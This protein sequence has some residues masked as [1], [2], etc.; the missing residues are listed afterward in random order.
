[1]ARGRAFERLLR[2]ALERHPGEYGPSRFEA[3]WLWDE[4]PDR[5]ASGYGH[6]L[7][8]DLVA[9]QSEAY[10]GGLCAIQAKFYDTGRIDKGDVDSFISAS[11]A[12]LFTSRLLMVTGSLT[13]HA[14]TVVSK[15]SPRCEV[16][17][18]SEIES[19]PVRWEEFLDA[20][21]RLRFEPEPF[22]PHPF[23]A[24]A[25]EAVV[26]GFEDDDRGR[27]ILPCGTGKSVV[28]LWI[29]ERMAGRGGRVLYLVPSIA[30]MGQTMRHWARRRDPHAPHRYIGICSDTGAG[31]IG[32]DAELAELA[33]PVTT[34][35]E[36]ITAQLSLAGPGAMSVVFC[37]YHSLP[38]VVQ[39]QEA[40]APPFDLVI[41]DEAHRTTGAATAA[42]GSHFTLVHDDEAVLARK[43]LYMTATPRLFTESVK[44]KAAERVAAGGD[45][46]VFSMDDEETYG[47]EFYRMGYADAVE[48]GY[49]SDYQ[50][51]VIA[52]AEDLMIDRMEGVTLS[53]GPIIK[54]EDAVK[55]LGCW[56]ALADPTTEA[57][58]ERRT[59]V[60]NTDESLVAHRA[61]AFTNTIGMSQRVETYW[62]RVI[63]GV[64]SPATATEGLLACEVQHTDGSRNA[65]DRARVIA[66][67]QEGDPSGGCRIVTNARCL[68]EGVDVPALDAV[69][70]IEPKKSQTDVVQA[71]GRVMRS[72]EGKTYGYVVLPV[73]VPTGQRVEDTLDGS[74]FKQVWGV[75]KAL[76]SHDGRLDVAIN[77]ADLT[78]KPPFTILPRG[79][80][81]TCGRAGCDGGEECAAPIW[82]DG[83][84]QIR[85]PFDV[86]KIASKLVEKCGD[87]QYWG[88]WGAK[89]AEVTA[90]IAERIRAALRASPTL[91]DE[92]DRFCGAMR[93]T[94]GTHLR[95]N[96]LVEMLAQHIVTVP[97]FD[98]MFAGSGFADR[99]PISKAL[100][101]LLDE[102][103]THEVRL[104]DETRDLERF[105]QSV[106]DR[107]SGAAGSEARLRVLLEVYESFFAAAMPDAVQR[108]GI[109]YTPVQLVDFIL[110]SADAVLRAEFGRGLTDEGVHILDPFT[111]TGT[112]INRLLTLRGADGEFLIRDKDLKGKFGGSTAGGVR[113]AN[114]RE[115]STGD[116]GEDSSVAGAGRSEIHANEIVLLAYYLAAIKIEEGYNER[117][118][119][120][121]PFEGIVLADTFLMADDR[122][123][124]GIGSI[125]HNSDRARQQN[126]LPIQ[127]IVGNPPWSAG[128]KSAGHDNP[129]IDYPH[130]EQRVRDTYG[131]RHKEV[132]GRG[133]GKSAGNNYVQ[134]IRWASD[135]LGSLGDPDPQPGVVA[136]VHPNSLSNGTSLAGMRAALRDEFTDIYVVNLRGDAYKSGDEFAKEG[137]KLFG[138]G[139]RNGVQIT[140]LVRNPAKD[141][142][143]P[144]TLRYAGVPESSNL[145]AKFSWL[146]ELGDVTSD[147]FREVR[148]NTSHD[149]LNLTDGT[150]E[151]LLPVC[152]LARQS[153]G[154]EMFAA[155]ALGLATNC[156]VYVY[157]FSREVLAR[158]VLRL[159]DAYED[160]REL[161][162]L[163]E[164]LEAV[165]T[166][167]DLPREAIL[168]SGTSNMTFQALAAGTIPDLASIKGSRQTRALPRWR[169]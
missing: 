44:A 83:D 2:F 132:T 18:G 126:T 117:T 30:L 67:L 27:L 105:Y 38:L 90:T 97:V 163:G 37:T 92:F 107:L 48:G 133:A 109:V 51:L 7:G 5:A 62:G 53:G 47:P 123:L 34:D 32:E 157:S 87:R 94:V 70:F 8:I 156:D 103:K 166:M 72:S 165:L 85:L 101:E 131:V 66:W 108:L 35:P 128:Q 164:P 141:L 116:P 29:A 26:E 77:T 10:G 9:R 95:Q 40:G 59:G 42:P 115:L 151:K 76:R 150:F 138:G 43:R 65:L 118:G 149:W 6:D 143:V 120:Y 137:D 57:P 13:G 91:A 119:S 21:D 20:P 146:K 96:H 89:V 54:T 22:E 61:I 39:A 45:I 135:R 88:R 23:Q 130:M 74:D 78:G 142:S 49:L 31:H 100:N 106:R 152:E 17:H 60:R 55:L 16:L 98:A 75:L 145:Q 68:T 129:N 12:E 79:L 69:L 159:I 169:R 41:C 4:W 134:A 104:A 136:F 80:C 86:G 122:R 56:D 154:D 167:R 28:A 52:V 46:D 148:V 1:M 125:R 24:E 93:A 161:Y 63:D 99:N 33:M 112:F 64:A 153:T 58:G 82:A 160:A 102:F 155:H 110:R 147:Q 158:R 3:V 124:P 144:A 71:V 114:G 127:V 11:S 84:P 25:V 113:G 73:V 81:G 36:R 162:E 19:W 111:G 14:A 139:S 50:V 121:E 168:I 15:A 140:M